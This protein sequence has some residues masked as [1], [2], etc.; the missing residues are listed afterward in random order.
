[1]VGFAPCVGTAVVAARARDGVQEQYH[2]LPALALAVIG[3]V[4]FQWDRRVHQPRSVISSVLLFLGVF[5]ALPAAYWLWSP[6]LG[7]LA[8]VCNLGAFLFSHFAIPAVA[9]AGLEESPI[10][11]IPVSRSLGSLW[12]ISWMLLPLPMN[13]DQE[14]TNWLQIRSSRLSSY[15]LDYLD[16]PHLQMGNVLEIASGRLF[17]EEGLF[18]SPVAIY[19][20]LR[21]DLARIRATSFAMDPSVL[22]AVRDGLRGHHECRPDFVS[23]GGFASLWS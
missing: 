19:L 3:L 6:W 4:F 10:D 17:V 5:I 21:C 20:D 22:C 2:Y 8:F 11:T 12:P 1:M 23:C 16:I 14:L 13:L 9:K 18:R 7:A 15:L